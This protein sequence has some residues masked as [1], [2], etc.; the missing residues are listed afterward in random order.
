VG[1]VSPKSQACLLSSVYRLCLKCW[2]MP[3][4]SCQWLRDIAFW[5]EEGVV[6]ALDGEA[7]ADAWTIK[8]ILGA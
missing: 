4:F 8:D 5:L 2:S 7:T 3:A 1:L 6:F